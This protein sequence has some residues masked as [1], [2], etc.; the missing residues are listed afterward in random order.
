MSDIEDFDAGS[1]HEYCKESFDAAEINIDELAAVMMNLMPVN[2][3]LEMNKKKRRRT[4]K[5]MLKS[6]LEAKTPTMKTTAMNDRWTLPQS[7]WTKKTLLR[8]LSPTITKRKTTPI[9]T[10]KNMTTRMERMNLTPNCKDQS[11]DSH[12]AKSNPTR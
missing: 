3:P 9:V 1:N 11:H 2:S 10:K 6:T 8:T 5:P 7:R 12:V 4:K